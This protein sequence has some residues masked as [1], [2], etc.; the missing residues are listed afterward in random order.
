MIRELKKLLADHGI[1]KSFA[2]QKIGVVPATM[3]N[4]LAGKTKPTL[5]QTKNI[6]A[7]LAKYTTLMN[8]NEK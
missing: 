3:T 7:Y 1:M 4:W 5:S 2:A 8:N 6:K